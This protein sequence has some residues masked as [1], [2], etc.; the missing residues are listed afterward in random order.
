[1]ATAPKTIGPLTKTSLSLLAVSEKDKATLTLPTPFELFYGVGSDGITPF[2]QA[3]FGKQSGDRVTI[4]VAAGQSFDIFGHLS[5]QLSQALLKEPPYQLEIVVTE[6][7][8][9]EDR[10]LIKA[11]AQGSS[12]GSGCDCGCGC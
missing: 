6:V 3:L 10:D 5:C 8:R 12:C 9:A 11:M 4:M 1:M 2:E 7:V